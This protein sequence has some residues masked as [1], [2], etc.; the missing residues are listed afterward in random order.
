MIVAGIDEAGYGPLLGP[1]VVGCTAFRL[2]RRDDE[3]IP[4]L[5]TRLSR[6]VSRRKSAGG[7]KLHIN[8]SKAVYSPSSGLK[9][10]ERSV[11]ALAA[12]T[13]GGCAHLDAL[14]AQATPESAAEIG[15][16]PWYQSFDGES[17]PIAQSGAAAG[18]SA[19][20]LS[21]EMKRAGVACVHLAAQVV[22]EKRLNAMMNAM[23]NKGS[24][25]F[26]ITSVHL[27]QLLRRFGEEDL[28]IVCDRQGGRL[29]YGALLRMMFDEWAM[30]VEREE[31]ER[32][33]YSLRKNGHVA[34]LRFWEK[35]EAQCLPVAAASMVSK[36]FREALMGRFNAYWRR[37]SPGV[38]A[39][40]G[41]YTDGLRFLRDIEPK[42]RELGIADGDIIRSR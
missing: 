1:L 18:V 7:R 29:R 10:L 4:C 42:R 33:E 17:F 35:A 12:S 8:D 41:Y 25:L 9:E 24:A 3:A 27:D 38:A 14:L 40:A 37:L 32:S 6:A 16:Y 30:E 11:L 23:R 34:R 26:S 39:T 20:G 13:H 15:G 2:D 22:C 28:T 19:N 31:P 5:W 36:Y 21:V